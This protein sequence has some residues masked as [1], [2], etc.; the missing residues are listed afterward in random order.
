MRRYVFF[1]LLITGILFLTFSACTPPPPENS[2]DREG[3]QPAGDTNTGADALGASNTGSVPGSDEQTPDATDD[4]VDGSG[5]EGE[6]GDVVGSGESSE[7]EDADGEGEESDADEGETMT[8]TSEVPADI[9]GHYTTWPPESITPEEVDLM[10]HILVVFETTK[11]IVKVRLF[12]DA[13][14]ISSANCVKLVQEGFYDGLKFHRVI[15]NFMSQGGDPSGDGSGGP[16]YTLPAEI[17]LPHEAGSMAAARTGD[18]INPER[19]SSGSQFYWVHTDQSC[20]SLN[21]QYTVYGKIVEGLDV[22][23]ALSVNFTSR[24]PIPG[25]PTDSIVKAWIEME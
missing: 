19:R 15:A 24:G 11:G 16:D 18:Q 9:F 6:S 20:T 7:G 13:A 3:Q 23:L 21:G 1:L 10:N 22:N 12:P 4:S 8:E 25:A 14:P 17:G 2:S 5:A